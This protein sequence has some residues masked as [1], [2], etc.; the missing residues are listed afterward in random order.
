[1]QKCRSLVSKKVSIS[2]LQGLGLGLVSDVKMNVSVSSR[3]RGNVGRSRSRLGLKIKRLG[4]VSVSHHKV[5]FTSL[6]YWLWQTETSHCRH[7]R[8]IE[9]NKSWNRRGHLADVVANESA[10]PDAV[11]SVS[12][13]TSGVIIT[14]G[15]IIFLHEA[16]EKLP[17]IN[18]VS[19]AVD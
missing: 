3:S 11:P 16:S 5:S 4:L 1:M 15:E 2:L 12:T 18:N 9:R 17:E 6:V 19:T 7:Q 10:F 13:Y 8:N 14:G